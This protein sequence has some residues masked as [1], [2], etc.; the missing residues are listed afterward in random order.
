MKKF[1]TLNVVTT[2]MLTALAVILA[3]TFHHL[4]GGALGSLFSPMHFPIL[5]AGLLCGP[6]LGLIGGLFAPILSFAMSGM[7][8]FPN[9]LVPMAFELAAYGFFAGLLRSVFIK[10]NKINKFA[11]VIALAI[12]MVIGRLINALVGAV[13]MTATAGTPF[14]VNLWTKFIGNFTSTWLAIV[15]QLVLIPALLF[16]LKKGGILV[17]YIDDNSQ[18]QSDEVKGE[19]PVQQH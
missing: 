9:G 5:V 3:R 18:P 15:L 10:N 17:K 4:A 19:Q 8:A 16:A 6:Y 7:P 2:A 11:S 12:S 1:N 13:L 14:F